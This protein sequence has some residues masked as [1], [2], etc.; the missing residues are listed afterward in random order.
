MKNLILVDSG[1]TQ[2]MTWR[3]DLFKTYEALPKG[4]RQVRVGDGHPLEVIGIGSISLSQLSGANLSPNLESILEDVYHVEPLSTTLL[5]TGQ[6]DE[7]GIEVQHALGQGI[8]LRKGPNG[9]IVVKAKKI[10]RLFILM[11]NG[12]KALAAKSTESYELWH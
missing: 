5:S 4:S 2:H 8:Y 6:L 10:G 9:P 1:T 7:G 3:K 11:T 12:G